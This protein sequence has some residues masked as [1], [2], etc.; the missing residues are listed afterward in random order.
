MAAEY[1]HRMIEIYMF[2]DNNL[3]LHRRGMPNDANSAFGKNVI[4]LKL[5]NGHYVRYIGDVDPKQIRNGK[6]WCD[7]CNRGYA[8]PHS[9]NKVKCPGCFLMLYPDNFAR[10][11]CSIAHSNWVSHAI[12]EK[13]GDKQLFAN[14]KF[15][16]EIDIFQ[17]TV[18]FDFETFTNDKNVHV[19]YAVGAYFGNTNTFYYYYGMDALKEFL[20]WMDKTFLAKERYY[21][22]GYNNSGYDNHFLTQEIIKD[23]DMLHLRKLSPVIHGGGSMIC[24]N[25]KTTGRAKVKAIDLYRF[26]GDGKLRDNCIAFGLNIRKGDFPYRFLNAIKDI[27]YVGPIPAKDWWEQV[28]EDYNENEDNWAMKRECIEYLDKDIHCTK[29]LYR[30]MSKNIH[31]AFKVDLREFVTLSHMSFDVWSSMVSP[32]T[33]IK[34]DYHPDGRDNATTIRNYRPIMFPNEAQFQYIYRA[35]YGGRTYPIKRRFKSKNYDEIIKGEVDY[36]D[37]EEDYILMADIVSQYPTAMSKFEYPIGECKV[38]SE[39]YIKDLNADKAEL[40]IGIYHVA[41]IPN[42]RLVIPI[43]PKREVK[44]DGYGRL[45]SGGLDHDLLD[46]EGYYTSVDIEMAIKS[47]YKIMYLDG[48]YWEE[49]SKVFEKYI[50]KSFEIKSRGASLGCKPL[51][52]TGKNASNSLYGKMLQKPILEVTEIITNINAARK[53]LGKYI[54]LDVVY[55][56]DGDNTTAIFKGIDPN[57]ESRITKPS[58]FGPFILSYSRRVILDYIDIIDPDRLLDPYKSLTNTFFYTDT[59]S[60]HLRMTP[61]VEEAL[62]PYM[63]KTELGALWNDDKEGL[64][65][66]ILAYYLGPKTYMVKLINKNNE[67]KTIMKCKGIPKRLLKETMFEDLWLENEITYEEEFEGFKKI[68]LTRWENN[69]PF[70]IVTVGMKRSFLKQKYDKRMFIMEDEYESSLPRGFETV[71][72]QPIIEKTN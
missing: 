36:E 34:C 13:M 62:S 58:Q 67:I 53:F 63:S 24:L 25:F 4:R 9:C 39:E 17:N 64:G 26:I 22:I 14:V 20:D 52:K 1:F 49:T 47:G 72:C 41:Y 3:K 21:L 28:P 10:H 19:V 71:S 15:S 23:K 31:E 48:I 45:R 59:D 11:K 46:G 56:Q 16:R 66:V 18:I 70:S 8:K 32:N 12:A 38:A 5:E 44:A 42:K 69:E 33:N 6:W 60:M 7:K 51:E 35:T 65:K 43:L 27:N 54:L 2:E 29:E 50:A 57:L 55:Y 61:A 30:L 68:Q 40:R 37:I